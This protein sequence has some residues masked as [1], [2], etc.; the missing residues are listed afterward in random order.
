MNLMGVGMPVLEFTGGRTPMPVAANVHEVAVSMGAKDH[1]NARRVRDRLLGT[2]T[3]KGLEPA[4]MAKLDA[5]LS[6]K[7]PKAEWLDAASV[8][9]DFSIGYLTP[10]DLQGVW[11]QPSWVGERAKD[12]DIAAV[13][14]AYEATAKRDSAAMYATGLA[15]LKAVPAGEA[16]ALVRDHLLVIAM[17]GAIGQGKG[18]LAIALEREQGAAVRVSNV[19]YW[20][21]RAYIP[22]WLQAT[23]RA[24]VTR[25]PAS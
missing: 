1:A 6:A 21:A 2:G 24:K 18:D 4:V 14:A 9:A 7:T 16:P 5:L 20:T 23:G 22:A 8:I 13:L 19:Y 17:L 15:G 12:P 11:I 10:T 3:A 25:S